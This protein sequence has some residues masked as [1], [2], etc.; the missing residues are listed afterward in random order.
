MVLECSSRLESSIKED[1]FTVLHWAV[2]SA[3]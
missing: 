3:S 1:I 2:F